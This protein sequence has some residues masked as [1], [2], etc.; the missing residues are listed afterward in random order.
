MELNLYSVIVHKYIS[1]VR[2][3]QRAALLYFTVFL[4]INYLNK[5]G[6]KQLNLGYT[7]FLLIWKRPG[8]FVLKYRKVRR[9]VNEGLVLM[10]MIV[11]VGA[12]NH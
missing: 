5:S 4:M 1:A 11:C 10:S 6:F 7:S 8:R 2:D 12:T 9:D 3:R